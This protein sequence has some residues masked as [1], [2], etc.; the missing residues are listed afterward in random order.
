MK[1]VVI[2][3]PAVGIRKLPLKSF[4]IIYNDAL[5]NI[6]VSAIDSPFFAEI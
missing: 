4:E 1:N 2:G 6:S 3:D 5:I